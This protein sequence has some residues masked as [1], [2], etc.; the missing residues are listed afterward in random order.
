MIGN[1]YFR[2]EDKTKGFYMDTIEKAI[3]VEEIKLP[4]VTTDKSI[5]LSFFESGKI[6]KLA[7]NIYTD[8]KGKFSVKML[9]P[10]MDNSSAKDNLSIAPSNLGNRGQSM[11]TNNYTTSNYVTLTIPKHILLG[12]TEKVPKGT[13]FI[14]ASIGGSTDIE[15]FQ[16]IGLYK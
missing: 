8:M 3:L 13:E 9:T 10:T 15:K 5:D 6:L 12:F 2:N 4:E 1:N 7:S 16:V 14:V 11:S